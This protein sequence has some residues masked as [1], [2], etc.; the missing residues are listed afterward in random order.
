L[1][2]EKIAEDIKLSDSQSLSEKVAQS[3]HPDADKMMQT[4][5]LRIMTVNEQT[6]KTA[7]VSGSK[8]ALYFIQNPEAYKKTVFDG[9]ATPAHLV[10]ENFPDEDAE[11]LIKLLR[12][13]N[14]PLDT[15]D[16]EG[17]TIL[18]EAIRQNKPQTA[19]WLHEYCPE[20]QLKANKNNQIPLHLVAEQGNEELYRRLKTIET[21]FKIDRLDKTPDDV[22]QEKIPKGFVSRAFEYLPNQIGSFFK[23]DRQA[24]PDE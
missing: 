16:D 15:Q 2:Q 19:R 14:F 24:V 7:L 3:K 21:Q 10:V 18:H 6:F 4:I 8:A 12:S 23:R 13:N 22:L 1:G 11:E 20:L 17:E 9:G 5:A